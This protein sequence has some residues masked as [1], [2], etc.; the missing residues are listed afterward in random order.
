MNA[1]T[2]NADIVFN[3]RLV[4]MLR[5]LVQLEAPTKL[6]VE[7]VEFRV[8]ERLRGYTYVN[9]HGLRGTVV[10]A[11]YLPELE[12]SMPV[13]VCLTDKFDLYFLALSD[14]RIIQ[15]LNNVVATTW[16]ARALMHKVTVRHTTVSLDA[17]AA[18]LLLYEG[19]K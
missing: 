4:T 8:I 17:L 5:Q 16:L 13:V 9:K 6:N 1:A 18:A 10:R 2:E 11:C 12:R 19:T 3:D 7:T 14:I 15:T